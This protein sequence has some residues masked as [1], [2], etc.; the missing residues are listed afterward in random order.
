MRRK[1]RGAGRGPPRLVAT[2]HLGVHSL[3]QGLGP[4]PAAS[5]TATC[6]GVNVDGAPRPALVVRDAEATEPGSLG[7]RSR[8]DNAGA[9]IGRSGD[10]SMLFSDR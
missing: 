8:W 2:D 10:S 4:T 9:S 5:G 1:A 6:T 7:P 3:H